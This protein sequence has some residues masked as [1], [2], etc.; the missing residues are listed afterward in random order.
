[1]SVLD[2]VR[3]NLSMNH[4]NE[5][6]SGG[7]VMRVGDGVEVP[8]VLVRGPLT[9]G[10]EERE[11]AGPG[12]IAGGSRSSNKQKRTTDPVADPKTKN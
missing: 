3:S 2:K 10:E 11:K 4:S 8:V 6:V 1:L 12:A 5:I 9:N 7:T